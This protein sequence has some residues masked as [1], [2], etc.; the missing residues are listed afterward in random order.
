MK[1]YVLCGAS[2]RGLAMYAQP[3]VQY[4]RQSARLAGIYDPNQLRAKVVSSRAGDTP[5]FDN[6]DAMLQQTRPDCVIVTTMDR[7]HHE[8]I[9]RSMDAGCDVITEK[10]MTI[11][12]EK[13]RA[14]LAAEQR[15]GRKLIV[16]FN[17]RFTPFATRIKEV[18]RTGVLG[19]ILSVDFEW[20]LDT[21][22][23]ADYFRR[24]HAHLENCGGLLVHKATHHFDLVNWWIEDEPKTVFA[25]GSLSS[26]VRSAPRAASTAALA[27]IPILASSIGTPPPTRTSGRSISTR[28][29]PM[30]TCAI[31]AFSVTRS[32]STIP[33]RPMWP[34]AAGRF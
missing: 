4:F 31:A 20:L 28:N 15:S 17:Y 24:W 26:T 22:H 27:P 25:L 16:T 6:F 32:I 12:D 2:S 13:C 8:Y 3:I 19:K 21:S 14:I 29:R 33:C 23:G 1:T 5:V 30:A 10:P 7:F 34:I 18:L 9:I 11:D